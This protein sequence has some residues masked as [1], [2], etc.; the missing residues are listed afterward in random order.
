MKRFPSWIVVALA[1]TPASVWADCVGGTRPITTEE[2]DFN[3]R[4]NESLRAA[5]PAAPAPLYLESEPQVTVPAFACKDAPVGATDAIVMANYTASLNYSDRVGL[6]IRANYAFPTKD[7]L[8]LGTLPTKPAGF[9]V[10]NLV[11]SVDG[12]NA[13]YME[14]VK[15]AVD[16]ARLQAMIDQP[17]PATPPPVAWHVGK[18]GATASAPATAPASDAATASSAGSPAS[19]TSPKTET[20]PAQPDV[21]QQTKDT[22]NKLRGLFGR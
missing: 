22:V 20:E 16:R 8:V 2:R 13:Q 11:V 21:A 19:T 9:K 14:A 1:L 15:Q 17:L 6:K 4:L 5:L 18:A 12:Y 10:Y 7:D 3:R